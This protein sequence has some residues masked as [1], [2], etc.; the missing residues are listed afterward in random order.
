MESDQSIPGDQVRR[1]ISG[2]SPRDNPESVR[3]PDSLGVQLVRAERAADANIV[4][5]AHHV[6]RV[7]VHPDVGST[8][9]WRESTVAQGPIGCHR[10]RWETAADA[11]QIRARDSERLAQVTARA[12]RRNVVKNPVETGGE[13]VNGGRRKKMRFRNRR[14]ARMVDDALVARERA[15]LGEARRAAGNVGCRLIVAEASE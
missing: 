9:E 4:T 7:G 5:A 3:E 10:D 13:L 11:A 2:S 1:G 6:E 15:L 14:I 12:L 8:H